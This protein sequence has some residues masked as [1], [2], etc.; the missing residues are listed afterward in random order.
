MVDRV[1]LANGVTKLTHQAPHLNEFKSKI[2]SEACSTSRKCMARHSIRGCSA[3]FQIGLLEHNGMAM[4]L[5]LVLSIFVLLCERNKR[6][7]FLYSVCC[8]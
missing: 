3:Q 2:V 6:L 7:P 1:L 8:M 5:F 4:S